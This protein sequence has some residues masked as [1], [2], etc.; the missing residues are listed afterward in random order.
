MDFVSKKNQGLAYKYNRGGRDFQ[1]KKVKTTLNDSYRSG[2]IA[3]GKEMIVKQDPLTGES[4]LKFCLY[5][6]PILRMVKERANSELARYGLDTVELTIVAK[7]C[8]TIVS[9]LFFSDMLDYAWMAAALNADVL[10]PKD[11]VALE[12]EMYK[13]MD[14][15]RIKLLSRCDSSVAK[16]LQE[17]QA[18]RVKN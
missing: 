2:C 13:L 15:I 10:K 12:R 5:D 3:G 9:R 1:G 7:Q 6:K 17:P 16:Q 8:K 18:I 14:P 11:A 4:T